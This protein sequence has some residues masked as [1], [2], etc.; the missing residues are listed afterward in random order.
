MKISERVHK[1]KGIS[2]AKKYLNTPS[3]E[4]IMVCTNAPGTHE[5]V[6]KLSLIQL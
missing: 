2:K 4:L 3:P 6:S 1:C 5:I